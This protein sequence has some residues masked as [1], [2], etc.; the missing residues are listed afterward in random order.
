MPAL[1][2][3]LIYQ[4]VCF[5]NGNSKLVARSNA[6]FTLR[7]RQRG[8]YTVNCTVKPQSNPQPHSGFEKLSLLM[9]HLSI[10]LYI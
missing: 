3:A 5:E 8:I 1:V 4:E 7:E 2:T 10:T 6:M 9:I